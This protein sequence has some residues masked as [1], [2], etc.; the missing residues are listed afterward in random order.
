MEQQ[1]FLSPYCD[2]HPPSTYIVGVCELSNPFDF[3]EW[4]NSKHI[5]LCS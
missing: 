2:M 5:K 4:S 1:M 3:V